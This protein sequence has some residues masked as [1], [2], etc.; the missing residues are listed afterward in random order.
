MQ[1]SKT[2][3]I[4]AVAQALGWP[5]WTTLRRFRRAGWCR[6]DFPRCEWE[7]DRQRLWA[8]MPIVAKRLEELEDCGLLKGRG[9]CRVKS[10]VSDV[11]DTNLPNRKREERQR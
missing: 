9:G 11:N 4:W 3:K 6:Q 10:S 5:V 7:V 2:V 1:R 8:T